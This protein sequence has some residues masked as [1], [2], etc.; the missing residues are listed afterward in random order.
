MGCSYLTEANAQDCLAQISCRL[1]GAHA[2]YRFSLQVLHKHTVAYFEC[3]SCHSLQTEQPYWISEAYVS[4]LAILDTGAAQRNLANLAATY[5]VAH[6]LRLKNVLD[7]GGGDGLL[8]RLLRD[9]EINCFVNDKYAAATYAR[10]FG[11]PNF[12]R[13]DILLAFEVFEHFENPQVDLE[14]LFKS[15]SDVLITSTGIFNGQN[16]DWWY[17]TPE[18]GQHLFFYSRN[19]LELIGRRYGFKL[20]F[21]SS[22]ILFVRANTVTSI[23]A[24]VLHLL[25]NKFSLRMVSA[26]IRLLPTRGVLR[27]FDSLRDKDT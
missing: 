27:D 12:I 23:K 13:P 4:N 15:N 2:I 6:V 1:C 8:C 19:A 24:A 10:A 25:M 18:T 7:Y 26:I 16:A 22:Y 3:E 20:L 11:V 9:Y 17:L 21:F 5:L 14:L